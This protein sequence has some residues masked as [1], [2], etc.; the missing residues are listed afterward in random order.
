MYIHSTNFAFIVV[1]KIAQTFQLHIS[2]CKQLEQF[3]RD[4]STSAIHTQCSFN[5]SFLCLHIFTTYIISLLSYIKQR[6]RW[7]RILVGMV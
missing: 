3:T 5:G 1:L 7:V 4:Y 6:S 2:H